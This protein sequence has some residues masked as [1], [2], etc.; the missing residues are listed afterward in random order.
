MQLQISSSRPTSCR[1][2]LV[3]YTD[4]A[5][6]ALLSKSESTTDPISKPETLLAPSR[7][8]CT[9]GWS[10]RLRGRDV[11]SDLSADN[12]RTAL[13]SLKRGKIGSVIAGSFIKGIFHKGR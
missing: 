12:P 11:D 4:P 8:F 7:G 6:A 9:I 2:Y 1:T 13:C 10:N 3:L 5:V